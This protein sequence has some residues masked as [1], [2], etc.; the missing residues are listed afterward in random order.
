MIVVTILGEQDAEKYWD[1]RLKALKNHPEA[2]GTSYEEAINR[3]DPIGQVR[4]NL[5]SETSFTFGA[6]DSD[7]LIGIGTLVLHTRDKGKHKGDIVGMY[8]D[9]AYR[10]QGV[11]RKI[12]E[13]AIATARKLGLEQLLIQVVTTNFAAKKL[14]ES[15]GFK[16]YGTEPRALK[17]K[18][19]YYDEDFMIML[20]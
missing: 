18:N 7:K 5:T 8:V 19:E 17:V 6:F 10:G 11:G 16:S 12:L 9:D 13:R 1:L 3:E 20:L 15:I 14:Y 2:F 4:R